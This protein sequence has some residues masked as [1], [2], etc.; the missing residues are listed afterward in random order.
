MKKYATQFPKQIKLTNCEFKN[1]FLT[2][3]QERQQKTTETV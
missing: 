3:T 1:T 2:T